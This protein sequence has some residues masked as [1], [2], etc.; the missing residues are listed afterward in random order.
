MSLAAGH[1]DHARQV[2]DA[3]LYEGYLL[4]P[5]HQAAQ[6]NQVRFQFGVLMPSGYAA[7][8][9][10]EPS[11]CQT[12]C[13]LECPDDA[14]VRALV[15]FLHLQHRMVE[16][17]DA[18]D[19]RD[20]LEVDGTQYTTFDEAAEREQLAV[21]LVSELL[22]AGKRVSFHLAAGEA[23]QELTDASGRLAGR[24]LR[25]WAALDG[26]ISL[27]AERVAGPYQALRLRVQVENAT[28]PP[29]GLRNRDD[30]LRHALIAVHSLTAVPGG[31]FL[32]MTDPPEWAAAEVA[33]CRNTGTWP[34]L[35]GPADCTDLMLSAPVILYDH[36]EVAG[37]SAGNLF[38]A[39]EIDE[40]L[41]LRTLALTD[42]EKRQAR[43]TDGRAAELLDR[44]DDMPPEMLERMHGAIR[45]LR[46]APAG[47]TA[48]QAVPHVPVPQI[49]DRP[50]VPW[51]DPG[52]DASV[53]PETDH[54]IID[55]VRVS[56]SSRVLMRPGGPGTRRADAQD[57][58][59]TGRE[60]TVEAVLFDVDG[61]V[62][63]A[64][65]PTDD[66]AAEL[67]RNH[68][69]FLYFAPDEVVPLRSGEASWQQEGGER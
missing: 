44:L 33:A 55:G 17:P 45:Y 26:V 18:G 69:R 28:T 11:S 1:L 22:V 58:F 14:E 30:G 67:N 38:D 9:P 61:Q 51:W 34:V 60:A 53:S 12:E 15:R 47:A 5:Y 37:E 63:L 57:L 56:R 52:S 36:P 32:S 6:K 8:D 16:G 4:Y 59:L 39:T 42:D 35:A 23:T 40:I 13:L 31:K 48:S 54:V 27:H 43:A 20:S 64:V 68:G 10:S 3:I 62:H 46:S 65:T 2:A 25:R 29:A 66:P 49:T 24:L 7:L 50:S 21:A 41:T 19:R